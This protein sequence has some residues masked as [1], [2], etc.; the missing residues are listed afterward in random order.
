[1][2]ARRWVLAARSMLAETAT[3]DAKFIP[4]ADAPKA[5]GALSHTF[6]H[7]HTGARSVQTPTRAHAHTLEGYRCTRA[8]H[9]HVHARARAYAS[10]CA[11][12]STHESVHSKTH[13]RTDSRAHEHAYA[14]KYTQLHACVWFDPHDGFNTRPCPLWSNPWSKTC[15]L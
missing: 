4:L 1:M 3:E 14:I 2:Q 11:R 7:T 13:A 8:V 15:P 6:A 10:T 12:M 9:T 5:P